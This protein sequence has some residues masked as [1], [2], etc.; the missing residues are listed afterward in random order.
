ML[1]NKLFCN[2]PSVM[3]FSWCWGATVTGVKVI[4][5][6]TSGFSRIHVGSVASYP[7]LCREFIAFDIGVDGTAQLAG[8]R[9]HFRQSDQTGAWVRCDCFMF[10]SHVHV[11]F[12]LSYNC[13]APS[14]ISIDFSAISPLVSS[15]NKSTI[16]LSR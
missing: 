9:H 4:P 5:P 14:E 1:P 11:L 12:A 2:S 13:R 10:S 7:N 15:T 3:V 8:D 6:R 16:I